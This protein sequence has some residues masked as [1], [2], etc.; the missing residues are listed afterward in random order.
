MPRRPHQ[1]VPGV[2]LHVISRFVNR[3]IRVTKHVERQF[4]LRRASTRLAQ[5][6][7]AAHGY[8]LMGNHVHWA[9]RRGE[10]PLKSLFQPLHTSFGRWL[11][12]RQERLGP[13]FADRPKRHSLDDERFAYLIAYLHNNP[14]RAKVVTDPADC[15][16]TSHRAY[17]GEEAPPPWLNVDEGLA[18]AG[19]DSSPR[20]RLAFHEF[21]CA[22]GRESRDVL[23]REEQ[24]DR[25]RT[26]V[27]RVLRAPVE[28]GV[29]VGDRPTLAVLARPD[30]PLR[31]RVDLSTRQVLRSVARNVCVT[32]DD[33]RSTSRRRNVVT[34][35]RL[36]LLVWQRGL[37]QEQTRMAAALGISDSAAS[38]LL[39]RPAALLALEDR[40]RAVLQELGL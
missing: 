40:A 11:N 1:D 39:G 34:G 3:E 6:D 21:V 12:T 17:I 14:V 5:M 33:L 36:A 8:A 32:E 31:P 29:H 35:R 4:Y 16:W 2:L 28:V 10:D 25:A 18:L 23:W 20:G 19:F 22:A 13:L 30:T 27:R 37:R 24:S 38:Q 7:A 15:D 26:E 9:L